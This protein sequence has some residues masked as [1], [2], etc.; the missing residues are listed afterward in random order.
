M[1]AWKKVFR[2]GIVP[3][4]TRD[5]LLLLKKGIEED[6]QALVQGVTC[7]PPPLS[8]VEDWPVESCCALSYIGWKSGLLTVK[9]V[10]D[11]FAKICFNIDK[12][13]GEPAACRWFLNAWDDNPRKKVFFEVLEEINL[14][15]GEQKSVHPILRKEIY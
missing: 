12:Q 15:L 9:E 6:D 5:Q 2:E 1:E 8:C 14:A 10:E 11:F 13:I 3:L 4:L 7:I